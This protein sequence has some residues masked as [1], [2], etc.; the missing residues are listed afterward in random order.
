MTTLITICARG[1][2]KGIP[3]KNVRPLNGIPLLHYSIEVARR[4]AVANSGTAVALSTDDTQIKAVAAAA[5]LTS[6]YT[7]PD[8]LSGDKVGKVDVLYDLLEYEE[9][10]TDTIFDLIIDLD[11]TSPLRTVADLQHST[12]KLL[13]DPGALNLFSVSPAGRNPYFNMVE[14][15]A[16]GRASLVKARDAAF[17]TRQSTPPVY[18]L[19]ASFYHYKRSFFEAGMR[20]A[21]TPAES[22]VYVV[23]HLCFDLD[24]PLDFDIMEYLIASEKLDFTLDIP[25]LNAGKR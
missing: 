6:S 10:R 2:S 14:L 22:L 20:V 11:V 4:Y 17:V 19:N 25:I 16:D 12:S 3:G 21:I 9:Q 8:E 15:N 23:P 7:R 24:E 18:D 13:S 5:G 1:G